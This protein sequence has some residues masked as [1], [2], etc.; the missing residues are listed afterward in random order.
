MPWRWNWRRKPFRRRWRRKRRWPRKRAL[1]R[2]YPRRRTRRY[3]RKRRKRRKR[4][5]VRRKRQTLTLKQWQPESIKKCKIIGHTP[6]I[7]GC[8]GRQIYCYTFWQDYYIHPRCPAGGGFAAMKWS[9]AYLYEDFLRRKNIWT[10][11]NCPYDL[12]RYLGTILKFYKHETV[13]FIV[14]YNRNYPMVVDEN[15]YLQTHPSIMLLRKHRIIVPSKKTKPLG[16][17]YVKIRIKPPRQL[18]NKWFFQKNFNDQGLFLLQATAAD[19]TYPHLGPYSKNRLV[20]I[21]VLDTQ[22]YFMQPNWGNAAQ[23]YTFHTTVTANLKNWIPAKTLI[24]GKLQ[25]YSPSIEQLTGTQKLL[26]TSGLFNPK[27]LNIQA[28]K[29][30]AS[31]GTGTPPLP[32]TQVQYMPAKD[33]GKGN[34]IYYIS[35]LQTSYAPPTTDRV[36]VWEGEPLWLQLYGLRDYILKVKGS[37]SAL[38]DYIAVIESP[39]IQPQTHNKKF[40]VVSNTFMQGL[41]DCGNPPSAHQLNHWFLTLEDQMPILNEII[42]SGPYIARQDGP[43]CTWELHCSY[44]SFFKWGGAQPPLQNICDPHLQETFPVPDTVKQTIQIIDPKKQIPETLFHSWDY[45]RG[46]I[47]QTALKRMYKNLSTPESSSTDGSEKSESPRKKRKRGDPPCPEEKENYILQNLQEI[48]QTEPKTSGDL[49]QQI[50]N[51]R[52]Q[53]YNKNINILKLLALLKQKQLSLQLAMGMME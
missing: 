46:L 8:S 6:I 15:A 42:K 1:Y 34:K 17:N 9:L 10:K 7:L 28:W 44:K 29:S 40:V 12:C 39:F 20:T 37:I 31:V 32:T 26:H 13:D 38:Q 43:R 11:S 36:L 45:R 47:T 5:R 51:L 30:G 22:Y 18:L 21:T 49:E 33:T 14:T 27:F 53:Q 4:T 2:R 25:D 23:T 41:T 48:C 35:T 16:K 52:Q 19:L 3:T 50:D 24:D